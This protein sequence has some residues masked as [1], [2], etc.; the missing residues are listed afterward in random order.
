VGA[1][2]HQ[3][4]TDFVNSG[5]WRLVI[6]MVWG[7]NKRSM[8]PKVKTF[9]QKLEQY[10]NF[11]TKKEYREIKNLAK[12]L[13]GLRVFHINATPR[14]GGVAEIL[15]S[16]I[17]LM[18]GVGLRAQWYTIPGREDF[19][20]ITKEMHNALQGKKYEL[21]FAHRK[22]YLDHIEKSAEL[23]QDMEADIWVV[24]D[25]QPAGVIQYLPHF[26]PSVCRLHI[27]L[28]SPNLEV[29]KFVTSFLEMY[30]R[31]IV[32]SKRFIKPEIKEK[33][34]VFPPAIDPLMF[35]NQPL[36][37]KSSKQI[38]ASFGINPQRPL[39]CQVSRFDPWKE[40]L[41][42]IRSYQIA[43]KKI[44]GLQLAIVGF[45]LARD[46]PEAMKVFGVVKKEAKKDPDIHLFA[47]IN[48]LGGLKVDT[49]V[50]A[51]QV[52]SDVILQKSI[53][54]GFGLSVAEAMWKG[55]PVIGGTAEGIR[56]QIKNGETGFIARSARETAERIIEIIKNPKLGK[57]LGKKAHQL[58]RKNFLTP[59]LLRDYLKLFK[60]LVS[61]Y[62]GKKS[63]R[64]DE[65]IMGILT[66]Y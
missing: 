33:A 14:G 49:F 38:L 62:P 7:Y 27:D 65:K 11:I 17:P 12:E 4:M 61:R 52:A 66:S 41:D 21:P 42:V 45:F 24:H 9:P 18:K 37:L 48:L 56:L 30:D 57:K 34:V 19:F 31:V 53:R 35:K 44:P 16:L 60:E 13:K 63:K 3:I 32:S 5:A 51:V 46:D 58:V 55:K 23:M 59:R 6:I 2:P 54:E 50:N 20:Q 47:D 29:W 1:P 10:Q 64:A 15:K 36:S 40:P 26:Y 43:K 25:P 8:L 22:K 28:T 39:I